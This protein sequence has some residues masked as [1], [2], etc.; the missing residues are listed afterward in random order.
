[1][2]AHQLGTKHSSIGACGAILIQTMAASDI[3]L[4]PL[5]TH[6]HMYRYTPHQLYPYMSK[7]LTK[8]VLEF[9]FCTML[10]CFRSLQFLQCEETNERDLDQNRHPCMQ[11]PSLVLSAMTLGGLP[12]VVVMPRASF[13]LD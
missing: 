11:S 12:W 4:S 2:L 13:V 3:F 5:H 10:A 8:S 6:T 7:Y 9:V 1:M